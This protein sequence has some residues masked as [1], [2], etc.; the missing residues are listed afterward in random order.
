VTGRAAPPALVE[1]R[2]LVIGPASGGPAIV[3]GVG[4]SLRRG[5][6]LGVAGRSGSGKTTVAL[7]LLGHLRPG[8]ALRGGS[9]RVAAVDPFAP[10]GAR[11]VRGRVV[12]FLGQDPVAAL[13]PRRRLVTQVAE[14]VVLRRPPG[15]RPLSRAGVRAEVARLLG[16]VRLPADPGFLRR[17]PHEVSGGQ[18]QRVAVAMALAGAPDL[19]VFDEPT[20]GLDTVVAGRVRDLLAEVITVAAAVL[21][22]HDAHLIAA[23]TGRALLLRSGRVVA[24]GP[25]R[26]V[27]APALAPVAVPAPVVAADPAGSA[28]RIDGLR[29]AHGGTVV[30]DLAGSAGADP[31]PLDLAAGACLA[32]VGPSGSGKS[33]L[34]RCVVGLHRPDRGTIRLDGVPLAAR[35]AERTADQR[36]ALQLVAQDS[37]GTLNPR[38]TVRA[39]LLRPMRALRGLPAAQA[40]AETDRLLD[41]VH[42]PAAV[43]DR[44]PG[45]LSGGERQRVNLARALAAAPSVLVCDEITSALDPEIGAAV[46]DLLD[47]LRA[48]LGLTVLLVTHDLGVVARC[49]GQVAV[50]DAGRVVERGPTAGLLA[51]P[52]HPVS[53]ELVRC[54]PALSAPALPLPHAAVSKGDPHGG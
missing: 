54:A 43:A 21:V 15:A 52:R 5:E 33:T 35:A 17:Y 3:E 24:D 28:L 38:E 42:L 12:S 49:A 7:S 47:E 37:V 23:L 19:L 16:S 11:R 22:S 20:G 44:R 30:V 26:E 25:P 14:A 6:L 48:T 36:R 51:A 40:D 8:L 1:V 29:A 31:T 2:D 18:A 39:A 32:L 13:H 46:I 53:R 27:L 50:L 41:R 9:V 45:T 34:A 4:F 10:G